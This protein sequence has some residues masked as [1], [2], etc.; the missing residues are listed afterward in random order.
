M[1]DGL[2]DQ[3]QDVCRN[4]AIALVLIGDKREVEPLIKSLQS[5]QPVIRR[6]AAF[7]LGLLNDR[8]ATLPLAQLLRDA[9]AG[10]R[11]N[12][13]EALGRLKDPRSLEAL[14]LAARSDED[15]SVR[16]KAR[17]VLEKFAVNKKTAPKKKF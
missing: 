4:S 13:V 11:R 5:R 14:Q 2:S 15:A 9:D 10:V 1:L 17:S 16:E 6:S 7:A 12:A 3:N 8:K